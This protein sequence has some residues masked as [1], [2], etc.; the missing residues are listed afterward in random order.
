MLGRYDPKEVCYQE[1]RN[2]RKSQVLSEL[3]VVS[4][5]M[6]VL[7]QDIG[8]LWSWLDIDFLA[9]DLSVVIITSEAETALVSNH[10]EA[11]VSSEFSLENDKC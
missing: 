9:Q 11:L 1:D 7:P 8:G 2:A 6:L 10:V 5:N 4:G 3:V